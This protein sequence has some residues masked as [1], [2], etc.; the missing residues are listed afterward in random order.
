MDDRTESDKRGCVYVIH[1]FNEEIGLDFQ[2]VEDARK[3]SLGWWVM[4][5]DM[6]G[7][8]IDRVGRFD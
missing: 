2:A 8:E 4:Y 6:A 5:S 3:L 1:G 7:W